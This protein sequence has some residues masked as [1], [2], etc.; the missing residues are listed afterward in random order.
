VVD[1]ERILSLYEQS[2]KR[3][4]D[5]LIAE[6]SPSEDDKLHLM[7]VTKMLQSVVRTYDNFHQ[8]KSPSL[9]ASTSVMYATA[10]AP[11][12]RILNVSLRSLVESST[13]SPWHARF[14]NASLQMKRSIIVSGNLNVGKSSLLN[15]LI[16]FI[17]RDQRVVVVDETEDALPAVRG[18]SF[19]VQMPA[20]PG[21]PSR[22]AAFHKAVEMKPTW[23]I[24][25]EL[26]PRE[27]PAFFEALAEGSSGLATVQSPDPQLTMSEWLGTSRDALK[28]VEGLELLMIHMGRD[29]GGRPRVEKVFEVG[30][31]NDTLIM[32]PRRPV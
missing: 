12:K 4:A 26:G 3:L 16:D 8:T 5:E 6:T 32:T 14:L 29:K 11:E 23:L 1:S 10:E 15:S 20:K 27:G 22:Q 28:H 19:T 21:T 7:L 24:V 25:G 18:R 30:V 13:M 31:D 2:L 9:D 17:P